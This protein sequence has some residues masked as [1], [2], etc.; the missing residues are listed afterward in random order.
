M[1]QLSFFLAWRYLLGSK[2][3]KSISAMIIVCF[4][5]IVIGS[6]ALALIASVMNGFEKVTHEKMQGIHSQL[7]VH[8]DG[9]LIDSEK[10]GA[11]LEKEFPSVAAY[12]PS[13][14][15]QAIVQNQENEEIHDIVLIKGIDPEKEARISSLEKKIVGSINKTKTLSSLLYDNNILI[16]H[17]LAHNTNT[18][19]GQPLTLFVASESNVRRRKIKLDS[20][21]A[22]VAGIVNIGIEEFDSGCI[23]CSLNFLEKLFPES[24]ATQLGLQLKSGSDE[25]TIINKINRRLGLNVQSWK[26]LYP[27]LVS[28]L[29]L[30]KYAMFFILALITLVASMNIISLMFMQITRKRA[31][32]AILKAMGMTDR[33]LSQ[34]FLF[35]GMFIALLGSAVGLACAFIAGWV[36]E[37]YPF[38]T[39][40]D[41]YYVSHLPSHM[42]GTI[43]LTVFLV[44][45]GL[46]F[47][48]TWF[49]TRQTRSINVS[50]VLRF[51]G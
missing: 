30:E 31:D 24:G 21:N 47:F 35:I 33:A 42:T 44:V 8:A 36:L 27:A 23:F 49:G 29:K 32:I 50:Q 51:E 46:S 5:G 45:M 15:G 7:I 20:K 18:E 12:S 43:F 38:I 11:V 26:E 19:L 48:S 4:L 16:G 37:N 25:D 3:E 34:T 13:G 40:P 1:S 2:Y 41:A 10:I 9:Q 14:I 39:L 6:F 17:K 22:I 28:A